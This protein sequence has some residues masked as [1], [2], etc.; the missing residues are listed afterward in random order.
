MAQ[1][2]SLQPLPCWAFVWRRGRGEECVQLGRLPGS[3]RAPWAGVIPPDVQSQV[4]AFLDPPDPLSG[5]MDGFTP[6]L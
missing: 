6:T 3:G 2:V 5:P 4:V 1:L